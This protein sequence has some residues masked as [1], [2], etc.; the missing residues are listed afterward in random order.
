MLIYGVIFGEGILM[1]RV[2]FFC[3]F[4]WFG[5]VLGRDIKG[6]FLVKRLYV[7]LEWLYLTRGLDKEKLFR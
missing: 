5:G 6:F 2:F 1:Y 7:K 3:M 4:E